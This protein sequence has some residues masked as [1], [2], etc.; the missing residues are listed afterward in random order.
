MAR[1]SESSSQGLFTTMDRQ[2]SPQGRAGS[3]SASD[4]T[5]SF[6]SVLCVGCDDPFTPSIPMR[7][8]LSIS[9][10]LLHVFPPN[11]LIP[12]GLSA[13]FHVQRLSY[14][15]IIAPLQILNQPTIQAPRVAVQRCLELSRC[16]SNPLKYLCFCGACQDFFRLCGRGSLGCLCY[17]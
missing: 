3:E 10:L 2:P 1:A 17:P 5:T 16:S 11:R 9:W 6:Q 8:F 7:T 4:P 13:G 12:D 14:V 15:N